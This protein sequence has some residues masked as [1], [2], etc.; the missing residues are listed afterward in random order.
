MAQDDSNSGI[1][2]KWFSVNKLRQKEIDPDSA[3]D[4][5]N[6]YADGSDAYANQG[7]VI[8]LE[9]VPSG[10]TLYF[11][12]FMT[13]YNESFSPNWAEETVYGRMDPIYLFKNT[14]RKLTVAFQVIAASESEAFENLAKIQALAQFLYPN[15]N[16]VGV[17]LSAT[18]IAQSPLIR[19]KLMNMAQNVAGTD[20]GTTFGDFKEGAAMDSGQGLLGVLEGLNIQHNL[21]NPDVGVLEFGKDGVGAILPKQLEVDFTFN[22]IHERPLGWDGEGEEMSFKT[23]D[24]PYGLD[25]EN[26]EG[27]TKSKGLFESEQ[28]H[29]TN[30]SNETRAERRARTG[31]LEDNQASQDNQTADTS[32]ALSAVGATTV[33]NLSGQSGDP[34]VYRR[35]MGEEGWAYEAQKD[36]SGAWIP[37]TEGSMVTA[38]ESLEGWTNLETAGNSD[39]NNLTP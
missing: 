27:A 26:S 25:W 19:F 38:V 32:T 7:K 34:W 31:R 12:A 18:S 5:N 15:Y 16:S 20:R 22:V 8:K 9:H 17:D 10:R 1:G 24:F 11:K 37:V 21:H 6:W 30:Q 35:T 3:V 33:Q 36:D 2:Q 28:Q 4:V 13:A 14:T 29:Y 39:P 23:P